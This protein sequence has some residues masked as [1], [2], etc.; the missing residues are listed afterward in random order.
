MYQHYSKHKKTTYSYG[1]KLDEMHHTV[2]VGWHWM[3][4]TRSKY[5]NALHYLNLKDVLCK[6]LHNNGHQHKFSTAAT[7]VRNYETVNKHSDTLG[8]TIASKLKCILSTNLI[9]SV[10]LQ[11]YSSQFMQY[12][13]YCQIGDNIFNYFIYHC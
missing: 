1:C 5:L 7:G 13:T 9:S 4:I 11:I 3:H 10:L 6:Q 8:Q 12:I 2:D